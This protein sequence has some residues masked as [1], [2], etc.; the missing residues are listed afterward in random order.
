MPAGS[1][2]EQLEPPTRKQEDAWGLDV[3]QCSDYGRQRTQHYILY[4]WFL[5]QPV[6]VNLINHFLISDNGAV[7][8]YVTNNFDLLIH[9]LHWGKLYYLHKLAQIL[10]RCFWFPVKV[11]YQNQNQL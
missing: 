10:Y 1:D 7:L 9:H 6:S 8:N 4:T 3:S 11:F 5:P 2:H